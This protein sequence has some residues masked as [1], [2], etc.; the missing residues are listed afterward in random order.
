MSDTGESDFFANE[1]P[2]KADKRSY[3]YKC[4]EAG[5]GA[6]LDDKNGGVIVIQNMCSSQQDMR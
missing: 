3:K 4:L 2:Q 6:V 5:C 1:A